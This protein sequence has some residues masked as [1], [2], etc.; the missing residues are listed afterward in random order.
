MS[1]QA[2][3][4][5]VAERAAGR[6]EICRAAG[7]LTFSHRTPKSLGGKWAASNGVRA[8][9]SGTTGCHGFIE[10]HPEHAAAGGWR[11]TGG[12][13]PAAAPVWL[14]PVLAWPGWVL[15]DDVGG[16]TYLDDQSA[17]P[18]HLP[19]QVVLPA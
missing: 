9:G 3:R 10:A 14:H 18:T 11:V 7:A 1:E 8:C 6:C 17:P 16:Y 19:P 12:Q 2:A 13:D 5:I 15:L 4:K